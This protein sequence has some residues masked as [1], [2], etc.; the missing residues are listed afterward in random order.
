MDDLG[1]III[2]AVFYTATISIGHLLGAFAVWIA[3]L[4][5]N[6]LW[7]VTRLT[8]Y[9]VGGIVMWVFMLKSGVH[10]TI[11]GVMLAFAI[12]FSSK[13][14]LSPSHRLEHALHRPVAFLILPVFAMANAGIS[15][16]ADWLQSLGSANSIGIAAGLVI[17]KPLGVMALCWIATA[18]G[19]CRLPPELTW[20]HVLGAGILGG[21]GFTMSIFIT[22]L[23]FDA[24]AQLV[25]ASKMAIV[26]AS[27]AAGIV[28]FGWLRLCTRPVSG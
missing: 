13:D 27:V 24:N 28:G 7:R 22:N 21:I 8:P 16:G 19:V 4:A 12:P 18:L 20:A 2:I 25:N 17:G 15:I 9:L 26:A 23:A 3:M 1:A 10:A 14:G 5:L 6:R 11:A